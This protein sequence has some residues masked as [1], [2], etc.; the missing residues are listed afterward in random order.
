[1]TNMAR[2]LVIEA[3]DQVVGEWL[4]DLDLQRPLEVAVVGG[5]AQ[6]PELDSLVRSGV[7]FEVT[8]FGLDGTDWLLDLNAVDPKF[9]PAK[10]FDLVLC[11][12]VL[13]H[14]WNHEAFFTNLT[15]LCSEGTHLWLAAPKAN[16]PHAS[17]DFYS[18]GFTQSYLT[19]NVQNYQFRV[20]AG[21]EVG[22]RR[23]YESALLSRTWLSV[24]AYRFP[25]AAYIFDDSRPILT[26][27]LLTIGKFPQNLRFTFLSGSC[28]SD[29]RWAT[30]SW[31]LAAYEPSNS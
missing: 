14:V 8:T 17:P 2:Q 25:I 28:S 6:E 31:T 12:Q 21:G 5:L 26:R 27:L 22:S 29:P 15:V 10:R 19:L 16:R 24:K 1:M 7:E 30:E 23:L 3:F 4:V 9:K 18:A 11:S 20:V 13:E